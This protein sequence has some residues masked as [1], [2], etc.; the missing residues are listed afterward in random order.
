MKVS[1]ITWVHPD[2]HLLTVNKWNVFQLISGHFIIQ[3]VTP[4]ETLCFSYFN[5]E[6]T[7]IKS[8][9]YIIEFLEANEAWEAVGK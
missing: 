9:A 7:A 6:E 2:R 4:L 5:E 3:K 8:L 1:Y